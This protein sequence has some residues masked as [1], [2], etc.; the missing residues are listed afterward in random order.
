MAERAELWVAVDELAGR[1]AEEFRDIGVSRIEAAP[2]QDSF[3]RAGA[4]FTVW[5]RDKPDDSDYEWTELSP[6]EKRL[7][8]ELQQVDT[9][10]IPYTEYVLESEAEQRAAA[11]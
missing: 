7:S 1:V 10:R 6:I 2:Y 8:L 11:R 9:D 4:R 5:L 3:G